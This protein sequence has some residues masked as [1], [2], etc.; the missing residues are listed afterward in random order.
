M[1]NLKDILQNK[2]IILYFLLLLSVYLV[3][4]IHNKKYKLDYS[5]KT[6]Q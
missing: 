6:K 2:G 5:R 1:Q 3:S 4:Q